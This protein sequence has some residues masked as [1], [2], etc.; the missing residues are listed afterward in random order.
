MKLSANSL[1]LIPTYNEVL[2]IGTLINEIRST[3]PA[4]QILAIDDNSSDGTAETI[5]QLMFSDDKIELLSRPKKTG[6]GNAYRAGFAWG[7][8]RNF[9]YFIEMDAD[10]S[11]R[12]IDLEKLLGEADK[13]DLT[14]GSRWVKGGQIIG[15]AKHREILSRFGSGYSR[16][17]LGL[18]VRDCTSG[19]RVFSKKAIESIDFQNIQSNGYG[20]QVETLYRLH[21][22]GLSVGEVPITFVER[23]EG[24]SKMHSGIVFE[25]IWNVSK[26]GFFRLLSKF[27]FK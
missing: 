24:V 16:I 15:W 5:N 10:H 22:A 13:Y 6:L 2:N 4:L 21:E 9:E 12:V 11:H 26:F 27:K 3:F 8:E 18:K 1:L 17:L 25:A 14:I 20:F 23:R 7:L 19:F